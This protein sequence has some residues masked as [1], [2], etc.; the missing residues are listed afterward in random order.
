MSTTTH[1]QPRARGP[2]ET[3]LAVF[4][5]M[6]FSKPYGTFLLLFPS[7][8]A[9]VL[10]GAGK[11]PVVLVGIFVAGAF[12]MRS[13]GCIINDVADRDIDPLVER[14]RSRPLAAGRLSVATALGAFLILVGIS[15]LLISHLNRLTILLSLGGLGLAVLYPFTKRFV[16]CPQAFLGMAFGW[17]A[18]MAWAAVKNEIAV[19]PLLLFLATICWAIAYDTIYA[20]QDI[21][22]DR[23]VGVKSSAI[24]FGDRVAGWIV[25]FLMAMTALLAAAGLIEG[26]GAPY[27]FVLAACAAY[28]VHQGTLVRAGLTRD[29][30]FTLFRHH[31]WVG[32]AIL[33]GMWA[34]GPV[35]AGL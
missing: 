28:F 10:A 26:L 20:I 21:D 7:L 16:S 29:E 34:S 3:L 32:L 33:L 18:F 13:A 15:Y 19:T 22:D 12:L 35:S 30:A 27:Y 14:T 31:V 25:T 5:L 6:R 17:G 2:K 4:G 11:P 23:K 1:M 8:W 24:L 9:L